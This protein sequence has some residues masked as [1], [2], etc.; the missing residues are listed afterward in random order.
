MSGYLF[1]IIRSGLSGLANYDYLFEDELIRL[2]WLGSPFALDNIL[3]L[4]F[5]TR[6]MN[7]F[8]VILTH[9]VSFILHP[10]LLTLI[11]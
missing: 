6:H 10:F 4:E 5:T 7:M 2:V 3:V 9:F 8:K 1:S 11:H